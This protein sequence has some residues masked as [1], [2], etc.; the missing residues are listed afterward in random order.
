[1]KYCQ[2]CKKDTEWLTLVDNS[3]SYQTQYR[4]CTGCGHREVYNKIPITKEDDILLRGT[5]RY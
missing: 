2:T 4:E 1:M 3:H 5:K